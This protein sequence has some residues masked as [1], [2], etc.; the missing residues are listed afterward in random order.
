MASENIRGTRPA[1]RACSRSTNT[2]LVD[3]VGPDEAGTVRSMWESTHTDFARIVRYELSEE[4]GLQ[5]VEGI[6]YELQ[7]E[8]DEDGETLQ[9]TATNTTPDLAQCTR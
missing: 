2:P 6:R 3:W 9:F 4:V 5:F 1:K 8:W 7:I